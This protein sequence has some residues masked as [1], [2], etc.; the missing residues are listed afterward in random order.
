VGPQQLD[1]AQKSKLF[2]KEWF[3]HLSDAGLG[4]V[5]FRLKACKRSNADAEFPS[6]VQIGDAW[7][8]R[9]SRDRYRRGPEF[10]VQAF[11]HRHSAR[12][13]PFAELSMESE[14]QRIECS[15][16]DCGMLDVLDHNT[17]LDHPC[18]KPRWFETICAGANVPVFLD[19]G[20][21]TAAD[22][23]AAIVLGILLRQNRVPF[24]ALLSGVRLETIVP[25]TTAEGES[26]ISIYW[27][28]QT[29]KKLSSAVWLLDGT[30]VEDLR[31]NHAD[32]CNSLFAGLRQ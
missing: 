4:S 25:N 14:R 7:L 30:S 20:P 1:I 12:H 16:I 18:A 27:L 11:A 26:N 22:A 31:R 6:I 8:L 3:L 19:I 9:G 28:A 15:W 2:F 10:S 29:L 13:A 21:S 23:A 17:Y 24:A 5:E 32:W